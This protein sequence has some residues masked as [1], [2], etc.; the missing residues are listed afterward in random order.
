MFHV[1]TSGEVTMRMHLLFTTVMFLAAQTTYAQTNTLRVMGSNGVKGVIDELRSQCE[2]AAGRPL[3]IDFNT[4]ASVRQRIQSGE[5]FDVA[6]LTSEVIDELIKAGKIASAGRAEIARSGIGFGIRAGAKKPDISTPEA[7]KRTLLNAK[8]ITYVPDGASKVHIEKMLN[9]LG[10]ANEMKP[11][12]VF[13]KG[14][15][16]ATQSAA[17]GKVELVLTLISEIVPTHGLDLI[18]PFP[19]KYQNY[20]S[21][22]AGVSPNSKNTEAAKGLT[23]FLTSPAVA[24]TLKAKGMEQ[25][26]K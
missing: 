26:K 23:Q 2:K 10:I 13:A 14:A 21:F 24:S 3:A 1:T 11:K 6:I 9:D 19:A 16:D 18:G 4:S 20:V 5:S 7:V 17:D 12:T 25:V 15:D 8:S 22:A